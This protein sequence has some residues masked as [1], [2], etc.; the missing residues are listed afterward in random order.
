MTPTADQL[1]Q[2]LL[3]THA[4]M[5]AGSPLPA[6]KPAPGSQVEQALDLALPALGFLPHDAR[7]VKQAWLR[8]SQRLGH[9][10]PSLWPTTA[11]DFGLPTRTRPLAFPPC[12]RQ[13]GVYAVL[14]NADWVARMAQA[15]VPTLQLRFKSDDRQAIEREVKAAIAA[16]QGTRSLLFI[17]DHWASAI[18][19]GAYGIHLG[20]EDLGVAP[21]ERMRLTGL[22][23]GL[24]THGYAEMLRAEA[25]GPSYLALGAVF[26]TTL[27][28][29]ST[30]PQGLGR[31]RAYACLLSHYPLVGIGGIDIGRFAE[32][33]SAGVGSVAVVRAIVGQD[34]PEEAAHALM[35]AWG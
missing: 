29:M 20:Q 33:K 23:L 7:V 35:R 4:Q 31:L 8:Q 16:T 34:R 28:R 14:P 32:V 6:P 1:A 25:V 12:P 22:R 26:P 30:A 13:L 18:E 2:T 11:Q 17:N 27:K 3:Q 24:S 9:F 19:H 5:L 21:V 15:G 10:D